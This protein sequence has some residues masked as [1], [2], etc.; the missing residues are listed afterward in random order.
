M[1]AFCS[2]YTDLYA[3][4]VITDSDEE[5]DLSDTGKSLDVL[6]NPENPTE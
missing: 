6:E 2:I 3:P 5:V 1:C 4:I